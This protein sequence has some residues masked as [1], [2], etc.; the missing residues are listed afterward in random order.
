[1]A[2]VKKIKKNSVNSHMLAH[3]FV[4]L[5]GTQKMS[6]FPNNLYVDIECSDVHAKILFQFF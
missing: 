3:K 2:S 5:Y 4:F 6:F 1:M